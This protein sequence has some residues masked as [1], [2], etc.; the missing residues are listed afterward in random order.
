MAD[1]ELPDFYQ[2]RRANLPADGKVSQKVAVEVPQDSVKQKNEDDI[3]T[4]LKQFDLCSKYGPCVGMTRLQRWERA[5]KFGLDPPVEVRD[6]VIAN[7]E[8]YAECLWK[9]RL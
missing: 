9:G 3:E 1:T 2:Q 7:E 8:K 6:I 5:E 4:T